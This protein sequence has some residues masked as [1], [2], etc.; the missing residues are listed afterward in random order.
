MVQNIMLSIYILYLIIDHVLVYS[1][2]NLPQ[3]FLSSHNN[4][5]CNSMNGVLYKTQKLKRVAS[6]SIPKF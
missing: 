1:D 5:V 3:G 2:G 4:T 6:M